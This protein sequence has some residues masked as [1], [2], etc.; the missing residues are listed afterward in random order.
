MT[1]SK[2]FSA[3]TWTSTAALG[4]A[5]AA[6]G[7]GDATG[8]T[9]SG[10]ALAETPVTGT[11]T[12][13]D[14]SFP[15]QTRT[16][17]TRADGTFSVQVA[18]LT[19][20]F[21]L[22]VEWIDQ[23]GVRRLYG[24]SEENENVDLNGITDLAYGSAC[25]G[26]AEDQVFADSDSNQKR[27]AA[28]RVR[29]LLATLGT[30]LAPLVQRYGITDLRT[31]RDAVRLLLQDVSV[32]REGGVVIVTNR[33]TS[34]VI[35]EGP[36]ADLP[37]GTF[38]PGS[39]PA[40]PVAPACASFTYAAFGSCQPGGTQTRAVL[41]SLP[42]GCAGGA[43]VTS[44]ACAYVPPVGACTSFTYSAYGS[45]QPGGTQTR[46]VLAS[47]PSGCTGG[48]PVT[49]QACVYTAPLDGAALYTRYCAGCH[50]NGKKGESTRSIQRA[51]DRNTG[52]MG[53]LRTLTP[54]QVAAISAAR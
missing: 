43:P 53:T 22:R 11:V 37:A 17:P 4:L 36:L 25:A 33:T 50:G 39:M 45:C 15:M 40:G 16:A 8:P 10:Q 41:T 24:V 52:G 5:L 30:E 51:I 35:F 46:T 27:G 26:E 23:G 44:R 21:L 18:G 3:P 28:G 14:S 13:V 12:L 42:A 32:G 20:P 9:A 48:A 29:A 34:G 31:D 49:V 38:T 7:L 47:L 2:P 6:C 1:P 19:T 54:A